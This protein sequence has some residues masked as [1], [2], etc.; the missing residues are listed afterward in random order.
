MSTVKIWFDGACEPRNPG[1]HGTWGFVI[2]TDEETITQRGYIGEGEGV[3]N[4]VA[5]YTALIESLKF[6]REELN[7]DTVHVHGDSQL[8][9]RQ[10]TGQYNV[11]SS[12]IRPL[13]REA[14]GVARDFDTIQ[15][16]WVPREQNEEADELS[17]REYEE[18]A[19]AGRR[20]RANDEE[21]DV[22]PNGDG[23][24][25]VKGKYTVDSEEPSCSCPDHQQRNAV[26]KHIF[27]VR[28]KTETT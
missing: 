18:R 13:W 28:L 4:N 20:E 21:M 25:T 26:C 27:A 15:Y 16:Q 19:Y 23:T 8:A 22:E 6:A 9:I 2:Q 3:T 10:M 1:G 12:R 7:A 11:N 17:K 5:E 24:F 14:Q